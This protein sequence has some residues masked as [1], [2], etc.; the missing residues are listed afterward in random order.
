MEENEK[1]EKDVN[2]N[3]NVNAE[4]VDKKGN[5]KGV[6]VVMI[7]IILVLILAIGACIGLLFTGDTLK[8]INNKEEIVNEE[9][10]N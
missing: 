6:T 9:E 1:M 10:N 4:N 2:L 5:N 7:V 8:F 3:N